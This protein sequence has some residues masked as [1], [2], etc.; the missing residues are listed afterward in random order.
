MTMLDGLI[1]P[2]F[3][4]RRYDEEDIPKLVKY[5]GRHLK[6]SPNYVHMGYEPEKMRSFLRNNTTN[7]FFFC[8]LAVQDGAI[9]G[10]LAALAK[11]FL[12]SNEVIVED[13]LLHHR[14]EYRSVRC[15]DALIESFVTWSKD[16]YPKRIFMRE[17]TNL[18]T[19]AFA[20]LVG[21]HGFREIG[22]MYAIDP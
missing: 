6:S 7:S 1:K 21:R 13:L 16:R 5:I 17:T 9:L 4:I 11:Q 10:G 12:F 19:D 15:I 3:V 2:S 22:R 18:P 8:N 20:R 14:P